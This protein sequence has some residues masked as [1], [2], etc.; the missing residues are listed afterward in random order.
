MAVGWGFFWALQTWPHGQFF[1]RDRKRVPVDLPT[2]S[3]DFWHRRVRS[4]GPGVDGFQF[5]QCLVVLAKHEGIDLRK[6]KCIS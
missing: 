6:E 3:P 4:G 2:G 5:V 1:Y